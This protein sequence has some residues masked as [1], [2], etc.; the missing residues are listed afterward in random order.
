MT[1]HHVVTTARFAWRLV[2]STALRRSATALAV[3]IAGLLC[4]FV[5]QSAFTLTGSQL[6]ERDLGRFDNSLQ[7][8]SSTPARERPAEMVEAA[9]AAAAAD[10]TGV[11]T[12]LTS[13]DIYTA[14]ARARH[15]SYIERDWSGNPFPDRFRL[16]DG[17]WPTEAG[18][19]AVTAAVEVDGASA[20]PGDVL[21]VLSGLAQV[22]TVGVIEDRFATSSPRLLAAP[23]T[24]AGFDLLLVSQRFQAL[25]VRGS[26]W[27]NGGTAESVAKAVAHAVP[28]AQ[29]LER[30][31]RQRVQATVRPNFA[32]TYPLGW[33]IPALALPLLCAL[34]IFGTAIHGLRRTITTMRSTGVSRVQVTASVT[35]AAT[36]ALVIAAIFGAVVGT[37]L[38]V[39]LRPVLGHFS[40]APIA[41]FPDTLPTLRLLF[42][43]CVIACPIGAAWIYV[44]QRGHQTDRRHT[45]KFAL[46]R[47]SSVRHVT[48]IS[49]AVVAVGSSGLPLS[50]VAGAMIWIGLLAGGLFLLT[51][52]IVRGC[53]RLVPT[54]QLRGRLAR[55]H[56]AEHRGRTV[57]SVITLA[58]ALG[59]PLAFATVLATMIQTDEAD[60]VSRVA[61]GQVRILSEGATAPPSKTVAF[62]TRKLGDKVG[63]PVPVYELE[64]AEDSVGVDGLGLGSVMA[65]DTPEDLG[66]LNNEPLS[67]TQT[68]TLNEGGILYGAIGSH[69]TLDL[70]FQI[71]SKPVA[72]LPAAAIKLDSTWSASH[73]G[74]V[75]TGTAQDL[76]LPVSTSDVVFVDVSDRDRDRVEDAVATA[77][78]DPYFVRVFHEP[79][80]TKAPPA[81]YVALVA[82]CLI[83]VGATAFVARAHATS[84][85]R[86][87]GSLVAVGVP[88]RWAKSV[89]LLELSILLGIGVLLASIV[90]GPI[91]AAAVARLPG[92]DLT[93][94]WDWF[95]LITAGCLTACT[96]GALVS[97][98]HL[99]SVD[100]YRV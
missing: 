51:P 57:L 63:P 41:P 92:F 25:D 55:R 76:K 30:T 86:V 21:P 83:V 97:S 40:Q 46:P 60:R 62:V 78:L 87:L 71:S 80:P 26:I 18:E 49:A 43:M 100:R 35:S 39:V 1:T 85:R 15:G 64:T 20:Q 13:L 5:L 27:W 77:G 94:P 68:D 75:L 74:V 54:S 6:A 3:V 65:V 19:V 24:F 8:S 91:T 23:G 28:G 44:S 88:A 45:R 61:E 11:Q 79:K 93:L 98:A 72:K 4:L 53:L 34:A 69:E 89:V 58:T 66:L 90:A 7:L 99:R 81:F 9:K 12:E 31:E 37:I 73:V 42:G 50:D 22:V 33:K 2:R 36:L 67:R 52:E 82:L 56:L 17:R 70:L 29:V 96:V 38:G 32:D 59:L 16:L 14:A 48:A 84:L 95:V 10:A 47:S